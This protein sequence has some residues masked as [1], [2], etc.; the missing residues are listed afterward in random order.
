MGWIGTPETWHVYGKTLHSQLDDTIATHGA[1]FK[2]VGAKLEAES[3]GNLDVVPWSEDSEVSAIQ[4][5]ACGLPVV[6]FPVGVNNEIVEHGVNGFLAAT[7]EEWRRCCGA[8]R[9]RV[10]AADAL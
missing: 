8:S 5:M 4:Y 3:L 10:G 9:T 2:A 1:R 6:A 7:E